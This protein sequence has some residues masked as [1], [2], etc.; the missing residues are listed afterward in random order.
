MEKVVLI[1]FCGVIAP[2][3]IIWSIKRQIQ[4]N[5]QWREAVLERDGKVCQKC[6]ATENLEVH[7]ILPVKTHP[8]L[9]LSVSNGQALCN[10]CHK[11]TDNYG[12]RKAG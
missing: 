7:H 1:I 9:R 3:A 2:A 5:R 6:N 8:E 12:H 10:D 4:T 11:K